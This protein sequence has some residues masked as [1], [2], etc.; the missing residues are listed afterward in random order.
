MCLALSTVA[1]LIDGMLV[2]PPDL[3]ILGAATLACARP[4]E[5]TLAEGAKFAPLLARSHASAVI[6]GPGF[7]PSG[8]PYIVVGDVHTAFAKIVQHFRPRQRIETDGVQAERRDLAK[9]VGDLVV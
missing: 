8:V 5:I 4:G 7:E 3:P 6:V 1:E 9:I 2:G